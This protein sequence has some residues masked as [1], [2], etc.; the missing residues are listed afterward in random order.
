MYPS[1]PP[2]TCVST[3]LIKSESVHD[4]LIPTIS[5]YSKPI[6]PVLGLFFNTPIIPFDDACDPAVVG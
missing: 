5:A 2:K 6:D 1:N 3:E 4:G